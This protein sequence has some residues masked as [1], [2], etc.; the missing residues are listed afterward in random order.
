MSGMVQCFHFVFYADILRAHFPKLSTPATIDLD[1][2][3]LS[4]WA[5]SFNIL[6]KLLESCFSILRYITHAYVGA[7]YGA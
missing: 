5:I 7:H 1:K 6:N 3:S 2:I 4:F